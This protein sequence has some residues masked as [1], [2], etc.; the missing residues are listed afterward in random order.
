LISV[1]GYQKENVIIMTIIEKIHLLGN[2]YL[3]VIC[4]HLLY[5]IFSQTV[6]FGGRVLVMIV[7]LDLKLLW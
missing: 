3:R 7:D 1:K 2:L 5:L 6:P 4:S